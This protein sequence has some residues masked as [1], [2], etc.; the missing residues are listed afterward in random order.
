MNMS[1]SVDDLIKL[2]ETPQLK[3]GTLLLAFT[4]WMDGGDVSTGTVSRIVDL[5]GADRIGEVAAE[6]F[7]IYSFP[8]PMELAA[9]FRPHIKIEDGLVKSIEMPSNEIHVARESN[10][11]FFVGKEPN[12]NWNTFCQCVFE[13]CARLGISRLLFVGSFGGAVPHTREPR[14][15]VTCSTPSLH[16]EMA[17][18]GLRKTSYEGPGSFM[19]YMTTRATDVGLEM[20]SLVAEIPG[21]LQGLNPY[22]I[23]AMTRRLSKILK[24]PLELDELRQATNE[25]EEGITDLISANAEMAAKIR[26]FEDNYDNDLLDLNEVV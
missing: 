24:L 20:V 11:A 14:L 6:P 17:Q 23:E 18:Y 4:G 16:D 15:Y 7:Y 1:L 8:G 25:W 5:T 2:D 26:E 21:Y 10:L 3:N 13:I 19:T 12:L 9:Q 22:S